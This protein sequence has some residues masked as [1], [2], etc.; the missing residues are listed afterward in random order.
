MLF[1]EEKGKTC[2]FLL[3]LPKKW[4]GVTNMLENKFKTNLIKDIKKRFPGC[5]VMHTDPNEIQGAPDLIV[6]YGN[7]WASLE[8]KKSASASHRP[9]QNY[10]VATMNAMSF[11]RF[12]YPENKEEVLNDLQQAFQL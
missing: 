5:M 6:L 2:H 1:Y 12:I 3:Y 8:G 9:K 11:S 4:K 10:Y 7:K